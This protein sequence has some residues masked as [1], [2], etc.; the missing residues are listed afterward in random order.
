MD[1]LLGMLLELDYL[2]YP[3]EAHAT[4]SPSRVLA[5]AENKIRV[6]LYALIDTSTPLGNSNFINA[7]MVLELLE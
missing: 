3:A 7:S 1:G 4:M 6:S 5:F 2:I